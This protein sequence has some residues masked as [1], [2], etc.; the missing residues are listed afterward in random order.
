[1][2]APGYVIG[3]RYC[4]EAPL[5]EGG[6]GV[7]Y[8]VRHV[9]T[10]ELHALKLLRPDVLG[11]PGA[12]ER[13][14]REARAP[15][16]VASEHVA[17]VSDADTAPE[18]NDAP[19]YVMELL[20]GRDL[21]RVIREDGALPPALAV[22]YLR[23][24]ARALDKA[25]AVGIVHRDLKPENLFLC[26]REDGSP[27]IKL[28]D[29][30]IARSMDDAAGRLKTHAGFVFGTPMYM[31]PEQVLGE[32]Q[33]IGPGTDLWAFG[34]VAFKLLTGRD[35]WDGAESIEHL[36]AQI[37]VLPI[38][39]AAERG[40]AHG[41]S[42]DAWL[43]RCLARDIACRFRSAREAVVALCDAFGFESESLHASRDSVIEPEV[44]EAL[45]VPSLIPVSDGGCGSVPPPGA[46]NRFGR[47]IIDGRL[48]I[49]AAVVLATLLS[50]ALYVSSK[51]KLSARGLVATTAPRAEGPP[52]LS[53]ALIPSASTASTLAVRE[54][55]GGYQEDDSPLPTTGQRD[56]KPTVKAKPPA[57]DSRTALAVPARVET[58]SQH[59]PPPTRE[60]Q[61]RLDALTRLCQQGSFTTN[62]CQAKRQVILRP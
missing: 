19:Y 31:A 52:A 46:F 28:V 9:R 56:A 40:S 27:C 48:A 30:G 21:E 3:G 29:F 6:M 42:F 22:E 43:T 47:R 24:T 59:D 10:D 62:E 45:A 38:P 33:H 20:S 17:R 13:F 37:L 34:L 51:P 57:P 15:A 39:S 5:G 55:G 58:R 49:A 44:A 2:L 54:D 12:V 32:P 60:Q 14:R 8:R 36:Y 16:R 7:V 11:N 50:A 4:V 41:P 25:H 35:F 18:L 1:M 26:A 53:P 61:R 23:Q